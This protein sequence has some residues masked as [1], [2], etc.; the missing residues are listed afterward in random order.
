M[1]IPKDPSFIDEQTNDN[2]V[3]ATTD[4]KLNPSN[5]QDGSELQDDGT[6]Y[7]PTEEFPDGSVQ[8]ASLNNLY[9][10]G[11]KVV[12]DVASG[13]NEF[14]SKESTKETTANV[15]KPKGEAAGKIQTEDLAVTDESGATFIRSL[16]AEEVEELVN[17][18][19]KEDPDFKDIDLSLLNLGNFETG[20]KETGDLDLTLKRLMKKIYDEYKDA[21]VDGK[22]IRVEPSKLTGV[23][24]VNGQKKFIRKG[25]VTFEEMLKE[26]NKINAS[27]SIINMLTR[28]PGDRPF[29]YAE[30][31]A[32]RKTALSFEILI[33]RQIKK[34]EK[35]GS[36][37]DL[38]KLQQSIGL[39]AY[40]TL[41]LAGNTADLGRAMVS[42]KIVAAPSNS[43][44]NSLGNVV[45][46]HASGIKPGEDVVATMIGGKGT[47]DINDANVHKYIEANGGEAQV[48]LLIDRF[49][50]LPRNGARTK[51]AQGWLRGKLAMGSNALVELYQTSLLSS[52]TTHSFNA[53]G[54]MA[55]MSLV[56]FERM[57]SGEVREGL[58][59]YKA[60][61]KYFPQ[62]I[63]GMTYA[64][65]NEKSMS[66]SVSKLDVNSRSI[67]GTGFG[68]QKK[69]FTDIKSGAET[70]TAY[71]LD[72]FGV[73]MR[74]A[75]YRPML[76]IDEFFKATSR[77]MEME[78][79]AFRNKRDTIQSIIEGY[80]ANP[81]TFT[82]NDK[83]G[84]AKTFA[85]REEAVAYAKQE[86]QASF[87]H[88]LNS[89][90]TY[91]EASDFARMITFQ[92][93]LP[94]AF[95]QIGKFINHPIAKIWI[96]FYKTPTQ[97]VRRITERSG[98]FALIMPSV[99]EKILHG[100]PRER[101][102]AITKATGLTSI[103]AIGMGISAGVNNDS[104]TITGYGP[105]DPKMRETWLQHHKPYS[106][107]VQKDDGTWDWISYARY[108]PISGVLGMM[109][110]AKDVVKYMDDPDD[111]LDIMIGGAFASM[112]YVGTA[113]PMMQ[114]LGDLGEVI[115]A[116]YE[117]NDQ[118]I[119]RIGELLTKQVASAGLTVSEHI[120]AFGVYTPP[121]I[122]GNIERVQHPLASNTLP[123]DQYTSNYMVGQGIER[124]W[125]GA[126]N[127]QCSRTIGCSSS[128][129]T[130]KNRWYE[131]IKQTEGS[132]WNYWSP[133]KI[134]NLPGK[135]ELNKELEIIG[136]GFPRLSHR[137]FGKGILLNNEQYDRF[138]ELYNYPER[139]DFSKDAFIKGALP[140]AGGVP[141]SILNKFNL[142]IKSDAYLTMPDPANPSKRIPAHKGHKAKMLD[143][144]HSEYLKYAKKLLM[145]EY[146]ELR[147]IES[148]IDTYKNNT[149]KEP[150]TVTNPNPNEVMEANKL[151][152]Q[153]LF[154]Y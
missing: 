100:N 117:S 141:M 46:Q 114:F 102:E 60:M 52:I 139:G 135:T 136:Y 91:N 96:P 113:L 111:I 124:A 71:A 15:N 49:M 153:E 94:E 142:L 10:K 25:G 106:I 131:E 73:M 125:Y 84:N 22:K 14:L 132:G 56:P 31:L 1:S 85:N 149:L 110:D 20:Y 144:V 40:A 3:I 107:G 64:L 108:D 119:A 27:Q 37:V 88:T 36:L 43:H 68:L 38:A 140:G 122:Q 26:A 134:I 29:S 79:I 92:D 152:M 95:S 66:D 143:S 80:D 147:A 123:G 28:K 32:A 121:A 8:V 23:E 53:A 33:Y 51:F 41:N 151:N 12:S 39:Y 45:D 138:L 21:T 65:I 44:I 55:F 2:S 101:K 6:E 133:I 72:F 67:S 89:A 76:A 120:K 63:K 50:N 103:F 112:K 150:T 105:T 146:P 30:L 127:K 128:L 75:G 145:L 42:Q 5:I 86:G 9:R 24:E 148:Q 18:V 116:P 13:V 17:F 87:V 126:L 77:G 61:A 7:R 81:K 115:Q 4:P 93:E 109:A 48:K 154:G 34:Y 57:L 97:I 104:V 129:P 99:R 137:V 16:K 90:D 47:F 69:G 98:P 74:M 83:D 82:Y 19:V 35:S 58:I 78:A 70:G 11:S 54:Q 62:A 118:L 130:L 59:M